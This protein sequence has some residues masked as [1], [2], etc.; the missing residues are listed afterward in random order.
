M[1]ISELLIENVTTTENTDQK[2]LVE[3]GNTIKSKKYHTVG[4]FPTSNID[5]L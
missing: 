4:T 3:P 1:I 5:K 2:N